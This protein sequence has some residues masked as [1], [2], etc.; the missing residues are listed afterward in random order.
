MSQTVNIIINEIDNLLREKT[1]SDIIDLETDNIYNKSAVSVI[2]KKFINNNSLYNLDVLKDYN[3]AIKFI[4]VNPSYKSYEAMSFSNTSLY[5]VLFEEW[6]SADILERANLRNQLNYNYL[7]L[8]IIKTKIKG[9]YNNYYDW[10][11]G[12]LSYWC[13]NVNEL[14]LIGKEWSKVKDIIK[15]GVK[16]ERVSYGKSYRT[17]NNLPKQS[18]TRFI[19]LRPHAKNSYDYDLPYRDFTNGRIEITKQSFWLNKTFIN[20]LLDK[21]KWK[22]NLKEE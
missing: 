4:P 3:I 15:E 16:L 9:V 8:P 13:P 5:N 21:Y 22:T 19:H 14:D 17:K 11:I 10:E 12:D 18:E 20:L 7:F 1:I 2:V 6:E